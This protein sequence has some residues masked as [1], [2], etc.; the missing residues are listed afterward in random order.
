MLNRRAVWAQPHGKHVEAADRIG[1]GT[2]LDTVLDIVMGG[3]RQTLTLGAIYPL[4]GTRRALAGLYLDKDQLAPLFSHQVDLAASSTIAACPDLIAPFL[5]ISLGR[6]FA[7]P[8]DV[9]Q[10]VALLPISPSQSRQFIGCQ[11][12]RGLLDQLSQPL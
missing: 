2:V 11:I 8:S 5:Q 6:R 4:F 9:P 3:P 1:R 10:L 7:P 12:G